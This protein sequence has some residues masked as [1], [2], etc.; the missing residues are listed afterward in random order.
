MTKTKANVNVKIDANIKETAALFLSR[1]GIDLTT[2][3]DMYFRQIIAE[4]QLPFQ[5]TVMPTLDEQLIAAIEAKNIPVID[6]DVD[7]NGAIVVDKDLHP[8]LYDW[9]VNG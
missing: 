4:R 5:P 2:A 8:D 9:A 7:E 6:L 1:M 3:V